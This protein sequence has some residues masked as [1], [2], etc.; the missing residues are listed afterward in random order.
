[1]DN[2]LIDHRAP[3]FAVSAN[4]SRADVEDASMIAVIRTAVGI[5]CSTL[6]IL[7]VAVIYM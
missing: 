3:G 2:T 6:T 1:M 4:L 7:Y 5:F